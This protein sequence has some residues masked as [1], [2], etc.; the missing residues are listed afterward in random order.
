[1]VAKIESHEIQTLNGQRIVKI[2]AEINDFKGD[3][4]EQKLDSGELNDLVNRTFSEVRRRAAALTN[5][6]AEAGVIGHYNFI[7]DAN[8]DANSQSTIYRLVAIPDFTASTPVAP[9][10]DG[11]EVLEQD[12]DESIP[13]PPQDFPIAAAEENTPL[14][15]NAIMP[16][17]LGAEPLNP[18]SQQSQDHNPE[19]PVDAK[20]ILLLDFDGVI[21]SYASGW[22][23]IDKLP[24]PIMPGAANFLYEAV[25]R[26]DVQIYSSRSDSEKG[27]AAMQGWLKEELANELGSRWYECYRSI[28]WPT[29][30]P[31]AWLTI[32]DRCICFKGE[33]PRLNEIAAFSPYRHSFSPYRHSFAVSADPAA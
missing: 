31:P 14:Y 24:D 12:G 5:E 25:K 29:T 10:R 6:Y 18:Q 33:F 3:D 7:D 20:K 11:S 13:M 8:H 27:L 23:G 26:F 15:G 17:G 32:D 19:P 22:H 21:Y 16:M 28:K 4:K 2:E 9:R 30:K 1:M